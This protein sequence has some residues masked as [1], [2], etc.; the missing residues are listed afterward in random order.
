RFTLK[1]AMEMDADRIDRSDVVESILEAGEIYKT[2]RSR[3]DL[4]ISRSEKLYVIHSANWEGLSLYTKGKLIKDDDG[5]SVY[6][7]ISSKRSE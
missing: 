1:A 3:S 6:V 2:V 5:R 4:R 7:L